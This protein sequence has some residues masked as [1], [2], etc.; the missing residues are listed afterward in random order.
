LRCLQSLLQIRAARRAAAQHYLAS[1]QAAAAH[2]DIQQLLKHLEAAQQVLPPAASD[3][4]ATAA[5]DSSHPH[6]DASL[7]GGSSSSSVQLALPPSPSL[8]ADA[9]AVAV[10]QLAAAS[11]RPEHAQA[12]VELAL[13]KQLLAPHQAQR[14]LHA[15]LQAYADS[16]D[17]RRVSVSN[18]LFQV[19]KITMLCLELALEK[20]L[21]APHQAQRALHAVLH[22][23]ADSGD[24][25][26]VS[27]LLEA[28]YT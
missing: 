3:I 19:S 26:G 8:L 15:V 17:H 22:A 10:R 2:Q 5:A 16:G 24:H 28:Y 23:Y 11:G 1:I 21:L 9:A 7:T 25:K 6:L 12:L 20:Q 4:A 18:I 14:A 27:N 13:E